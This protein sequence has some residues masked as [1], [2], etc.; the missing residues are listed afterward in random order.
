VSKEDSICR[1][2]AILC[3]F[4]DFATR[5]RREVVNTKLCPSR[6]QFKYTDEI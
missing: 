4:V 5:G 1:E 3:D 2:E 6:E